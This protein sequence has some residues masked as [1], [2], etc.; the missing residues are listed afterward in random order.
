M[1]VSSAQEPLVPPLVSLVHHSCQSPTTAVS[2][3]CF[4]VSAVPLWDF[5]KVFA[6]W[7]GA[8][9]SEV[10]LPLCATQSS[11]GSG[12]LHGKGTRSFCANIRGACSSSRPLTLRCTLVSL[13]DGNDK[14]FRLKASICLLNASVDADGIVWSRSPDA[15]HSSKDIISEE[16]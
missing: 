9:I 4:S 3:C 8:C 13:H 10:R 2:W 12:Y 5:F 15:L 1:L 7:R 16:S 6:W 11:C 14:S